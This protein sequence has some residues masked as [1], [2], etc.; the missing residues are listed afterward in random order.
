MKAIKVALYGMVGLVALAVVALGAVFVIVDG[1]FVKARL[2]NAMKEK[3]RTLNIEG[4]PK[5]ALFPVFRLTLGKTTL[6]EPKSDKAFV[7]LE[8]LVVAVKV[9]PLVSGEVAVDILTLSGLRANIVRAKDGSMNFDD[10]AGKREAETAEKK[11]PPKIRIAEVK[12]ERAQ[13]SYTDLASGQTPAIGDLNLKTGRLEDDVPTPLALSASIAG[14]RPEIALKAQVEAVAR[15]NLAAQAF[16]FSKLDARLSGNA[17]TLHGLD[18]RLN[19]DLAADVRRQEYTVDTLGL[20][21]KGTLERDALA[22][23]FSAPRLRVTSAKAEGQ[24]VPAT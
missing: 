1:K 15:I 22:A 2:E 19:G 23:A 18:L 7:S 14:K 6:S 5:L 20:Q 16:A 8:S 10:L 11:E 4:E 3:S 17:G 13:V 12:I 9:M 24:A 21:A